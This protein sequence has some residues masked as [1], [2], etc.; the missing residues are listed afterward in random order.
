MIDPN[1]LPP[2]VKDA[3]EQNQD[4]DPDWSTMSANEAFNS[5]CTW[6]GFINWSGTISAALDSIR[7]SA[8]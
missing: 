3:I 5:W 6:H 8:S 2:L 4:G 1:K 7:K